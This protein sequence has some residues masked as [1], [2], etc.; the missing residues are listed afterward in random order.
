MRGLEAAAS[1]LVL[2]GLSVADRMCCPPVV[3]FIPWISVAADGGGMGPRPPLR[4]TLAGSAS[5]G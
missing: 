5:S 2:W 4:R 1:L 3:I